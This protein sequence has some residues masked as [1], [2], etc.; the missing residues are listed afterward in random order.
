MAKRKRKNPF[1]VAPAPSGAGFEDTPEN[2]QRI[3]DLGFGSLLDDAPASKPQKRG[4]FGGAKPRPRSRVGRFGGSGSPSKRTRGGSM[5]RLRK[6]QDDYVSRLPR[7]TMSGSQVTEQRAT[8]SVPRVVEEKV[9]PERIMPTRP[10]P[11]EDPQMSTDQ[12]AMRQLESIEVDG[13]RSSEPTERKPPA[14]D[15]GNTPDPFTIKPSSIEIPS[16]DVNVNPG[17]TPV[18]D[19]GASSSF[20]Q[21]DPPKPPPIEFPKQETKISAMPEF[22]TG[23]SFFPLRSLEDQPNTYESPAGDPIMIKD[24]GF[25][26]NLLPEPRKMI[27]AFGIKRPDGGGYFS[28]EETRDLLSRFSPEQLKAMYG[29]ENVIDMRDFELP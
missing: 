24:D 3:K 19:Y 16:G 25:F 9:T 27:R 28:P 23:S 22:S 29:E 14:P 10:A 6:K 20:G 15:L 11:V 5:N 12:K 26:P 4:F 7:P 17:Y 21:P 2:R 1:R 8:P 13:V 18:S